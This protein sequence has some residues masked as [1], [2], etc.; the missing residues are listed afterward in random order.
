MAGQN[1]FASVS[2]P[3]GVALNEEESAPDA[4]TLGDEVTVSSPS[5]R[6][7][8]VA[9]N[10]MDIGKFVTSNGSCDHS[11]TDEERFEALTHCW[12]PDKEYAF[13][14][15]IE[16][17]RSRAF[18]YHYLSLWPWLAYSEMFG[19]G[20]FC[21]HC[22][23]FAKTESSSHGGLR[24]RGV[25]ITQPLNRFKKAVDILKNHALS[26][27]HRRASESANDFLE[28]HGDRVNLD[29]RNRLVKAREEQVVKNRQRLIPIVKTILLCEHLNNLKRNA[30]YMSNKFQNELIAAI[31]KIIRRKI[32]REVNDSKF[33]AVLADETSD[34]GRIDQLT[35]CLRYISTSA[36][37]PV[38][39]E[40]F[41]KFCA[42]AQ[43]TGAALART[44]LD[45]LEEEGVDVRNIR[46][47]GYDGCASMKGAGNGVQAEIK[48]VVPQAL[49]FHCASHCL[50][51]ALVHSAEIVPI[52]LAAGVVKSV[53]NFFC[54]STKRHQCLMDKIDAH[55]PTSSKTRLKALCPTR[56]VESHHAFITFR[57]LLV[58]LFHCLVEL[59]QVTGE[60]GVRAYE[61]ESSVC[62]CDFVFALLTIESFSCIFL[63]LSMQLQKKSL[64]IFAALRMVDNILS[65][66]E[67]KR[68]NVET[69]FKIIYDEVTEICALLDVEIKMPRISGRQMHREN[70]QAETPEAYFRVT[71]YVQYLDHLIQELRSLFADSRQK[72]M[73]V[74]CLVPKYT[75]SSTFADLIETLD[76]YQTDLDCSAS[77]LRGEFECWKAKWGRKAGNELPETAIEALSFCPR[78]EYPKIATLLQIFATF[79]VTT[80]TP[81]RTFS[82]LKLLK[83]YLRSTMGHERLNGLASMTLQRDVPVSVDEVVDLIAQ[84]PRRLDIVL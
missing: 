64:D 38:V 27:Y 39:K 67:L 50:S 5:A 1:H 37:K 32:V 63:P 81:E 28:W 76:F 40:V 49:Y 8:R 20:G 14:K 71:M 42:V 75:V 51:L 84:D 59:G 17:N 6:R 13:P 74:Q 69:E 31:G 58:P 57:E 45:A 11:L 16:S 21:K 65:I 15:T 62:K 36:S 22:V 54:K 55:A 61:L 48:A 80:S 33:Y 35:I 43:K 73:K 53:C 18:Q 41:L 26:E 12:E 83:T 4:T 7:Q 66:L 78:I 70:H 10:P 44:I 9:L 46:G 82:S 29:I 56:W 23:L 60:T 30:T 3:S 34:A 24:K 25:L 2:V 79:P 52:K 19:G 47:Q 68:Q 77:V 72:A